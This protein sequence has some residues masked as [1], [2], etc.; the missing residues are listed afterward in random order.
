MQL[1]KQFNSNPSVK[2]ILPSSN[3][4]Q[5]NGNHITEKSFQLVED[6]LKVLSM[7]VVYC[8]RK[9]GCC[10]ETSGI[11]GRE[12]NILHYPDALPRTLHV[13]AYIL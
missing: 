8:R 7:D 1:K 5:L 3:C 6:P 11:G 12:C 10:T 2:L 9:G 13:V 4:M